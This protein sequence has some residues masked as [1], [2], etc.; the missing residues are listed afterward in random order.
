MEGIKKDSAELVRNALRREFANPQ[1]RLE[2]SGPAGAPYSYANA[3]RVAGL[4]AHVDFV[5]PP[6]ASTVVEARFRCPRVLQW[7]AMLVRY[8]QQK[9]F[10][11]TLS[12]RTNWHN[13]IVDCRAPKPSGKNNA[14]IFMCF[15]GH[16]QIPARDVLL[17]PTMATPAFKCDIP[18]HCLHKRRWIGWWMTY[19]RRPEKRTLK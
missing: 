19:R 8:R 10:F 11:R 13:T 15:V 7:Y 12:R 3:V 1:E 2:A 6:A 18:R 4:G 14:C 17:E 16:C 9:Y 5:M